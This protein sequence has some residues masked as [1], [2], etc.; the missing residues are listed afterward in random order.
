MH[1]ACD[2]VDYPARGG[3]SAYRACRTC[4]AIWDPDEGEVGPCEDAAHPIW[5]AVLAATLACLCVGCL[6]AATALADP[7]L[8]PALSAALGRATALFGG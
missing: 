5:P 2:I 7:F 6:L 3:E 8:W 1:E 4:H